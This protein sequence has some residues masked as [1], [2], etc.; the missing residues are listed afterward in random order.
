MVVFEINCK[1]VSVFD[2]LFV[3]SAVLDVD[4]FSNI[5]RKMTNGKNWNARVINQGVVI[6]LIKINHGN[7]FRIVYQI[8]KSRT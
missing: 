4:H 2:T 6:S 5:G 1:T 3:I 7:S 8:C